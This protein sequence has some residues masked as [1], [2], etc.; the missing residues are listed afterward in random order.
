LI[1]TNQ[2]IT[3]L[4]IVPFTRN[5]ISCVDEVSGQVAGTELAV[6]PMRKPGVVAIG[7][8]IAKAISTT[9]ARVT[10]IFQAFTIYPFLYP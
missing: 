10:T 6:P 9:A 2:I 8:R 3:T 5:L 4:G 1:D 7:K